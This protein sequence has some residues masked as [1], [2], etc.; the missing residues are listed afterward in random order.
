MTRFACRFLLPLVLVVITGSS[1]T[2]TV[3]YKVSFEHPEKHLFSVEMALPPVPARTS[4]A[5]PAWNA[6]YQVRDFAY[7]MRELRLSAVDSGG[8]SVSGA[9]LI[10]VDKDTWTIEGGDGAAYVIHY[11]IEWND[12]GP[13]NSQLNSE[14]A[15]V[16]FAEILMYL[17]DR[18]GE[19]AEVTFENVP[20]GWRLAAELPRGKLENSF[21]AESYDKLVDAPVEAGTFGEFGFDETGAHFRVV[22]DAKDW[23]REKPQFA[24]ELQRLV[25]YET[26][27]MGGAPFREYTFFFHLGPYAEVGGGGMEHSNCTAISASSEPGAISVAAHEFFHAWNVKRIRPQALEPVDYSKEQYTRALWFA[28][29]V[30]STYASFALVRSGVWNSRQFYGDFADQLQRLDSSPARLWQS[31]EESSLDAW[32][33]KYDSYYSP[34]RSISYYN[35]GQILGVLLDIAIRDETENKKS[36][37][38]VVRALN[39]NFAKR[40]RFYNESADIRAAAEAVSG[41]SFEEFFR[42]YVSGMEEISYD[43]FLAKAGLRLSRTNKTS[44]DL[45]FVIARGPGADFLISA[46]TRGSSADSAGLRRGDAIVQING[47][48]PSPA[49]FRRMRAHSPGDTLALRVRRESQ[50]QDVSLKLG[51]RDESQYSISEI[52]NATEKQRL[53]RDGLLR[54]TTN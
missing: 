12:S 46:V 45:G 35:K 43:D 25:K 30:T 41:K 44:A 19:D 5:L 10:P 18:R 6:L 39:E 7:R 4:V 54:G 34:E 8:K 15:F 3:R 14:H 53:I 38:D 2:G 51:A 20:A 28:E 47:E 37:D 49:Q 21:V 26:G 52:A 22:V 16:N 50:E 42:R 23:E 36:L 29:G 11:E 1:A 17:P 33:E 24:S 9:R 31:V 40:G 32:L 48:S 27:L 13:F